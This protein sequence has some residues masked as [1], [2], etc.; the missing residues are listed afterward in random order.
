MAVLQNKIILREAFS[1]QRPGR[2][3]S[4]CAALSPGC[5]LILGAEDF[6]GRLENINKGY[7]SLFWHGVKR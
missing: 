4:F 7:C 1:P 6:C 2:A 5:F 3:V